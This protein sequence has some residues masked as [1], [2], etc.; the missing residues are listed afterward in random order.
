MINY[1]D[2][3]RGRFGVEPIC[4]TL[5]ASGIEIAPSTYYA[6]KTRAPSAR[7][8]RDDELRHLIEEAHRQNYGVYGVRKLWQHLLGQNVEVARCTVARLMAGLGLRGVVR[9][10]RRLTTFAEEG[11]ERSP[12]LVK[13]EFSASAPN[14]LWVAD[15]TYVPSWSGTVYVSF[16]IDAYSRRLLGWKASCNMRTELVLDTIEMALWSRGLNGSK[17]RAVGLIHHSDRGSQ[18]TSVAFTQRLLEA[19]IDAS[20]GSVGD[21][22]DNALAE[23]TI[24]LYKTELI[25]RKSWKTFAE[26]ECQTSEWVDWYNHRR[27]HSALGYRSPAAFEAANHLLSQLDAVSDEASA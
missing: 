9:G 6:A 18:Y 1:I 24:G 20:V 25:A 27:L 10:K 26:V 3:H 16:V 13:R 23:T 22:Y 7:S 19:G 11:A 2:Q 4:K 17:Q 21:G 15:F 12:D 5:R 8:V 14:R